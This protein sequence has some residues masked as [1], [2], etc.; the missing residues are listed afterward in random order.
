[1]LRTDQ[2]LNVTPSSALPTETAVM[3]SIDPLRMGLNADGYDME[4]MSIDDK[5]R[6]RVIAMDDACEDCLVPQEVMARIIASTL[7][8][9]ESAVTPDDIVI[10]YPAEH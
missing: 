1:M 10:S 2:G 8:A 9:S 5:I 7:Q 6:L 4:I 3:A